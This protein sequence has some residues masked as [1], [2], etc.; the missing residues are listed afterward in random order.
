MLQL[1]QE[2]LDN[3]LADWQLNQRYSD[4]LSSYLIIDSMISYFKQR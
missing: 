1:V 2:L 3:R 4:S